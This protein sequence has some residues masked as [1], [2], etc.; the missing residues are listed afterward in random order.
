MDVYPLAA[1]NGP[2][3]SQ[4]PLPLSQQEE[5]EEEEE[6]YTVH[7]STTDTCELEFIYS[8]KTFSQEATFQGF[9]MS[10]YVT[11]TARFAINR[12]IT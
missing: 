3:A 10:V 9:H 11:K 4:G 5:E 2:G 8:V 12:L 6:G 1:Q 7:V